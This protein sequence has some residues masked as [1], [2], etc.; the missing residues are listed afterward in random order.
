MNK[1]TRTKIAIRTP[2]KKAGKKGA[3]VSRPA[4]HVSDTDAFAISL[5]EIISTVD[6]A[7][8]LTTP[9]LRA[10][11][12]LLRIAAET[13]SSGDASVIVRDHRPRGGMKFLVA[14]GAVADQLLNIKIPSGEGI[15]GFVFASGQPVVVANVQQEKSFY[16]EVDRQTGYSTHTI[17][18]TPLQVNGRT[19]GVLEFVNRLGESPHEPFTPDEMD[20][21]ARFAEA[22][23]ALVDAHETTGL[24]EVLF[25]RLT[26]QAVEQQTSRQPRQRQDVKQKNGGASLQQWLKQVR[27]APEHRELISLALA[28]RDI[29]SRGDAERKLCHDILNSLARWTSTRHHRHATLTASATYFD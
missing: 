22:I 5:R 8:A 13:L 29:A 12:N 19:I 24:I 27:A 4:T 26:S 11:E 2:P 7:H 15:A 9:F 25:Q 1:K 3:S 14:I 6:V 28:L 23:A 17:L 16:L 21:A 20:T 10:I 18:A